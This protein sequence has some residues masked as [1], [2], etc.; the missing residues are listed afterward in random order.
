LQVT[1][2]KT[3]RRRGV[4]A[5]NRLRRGGVV[6]SPRLFGKKTEKDGNHGV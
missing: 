1:K 5:Q 3:P 6:T 2:K 4:K